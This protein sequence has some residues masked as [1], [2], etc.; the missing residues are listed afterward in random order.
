MDI[1]H[2]RRAET[3]AR[4]SMT[5]WRAAQA[6]HPQ[7]FE[8]RGFPVRIECT[9]DLL[10]LTDTMQEDRFELYQRELGGLSVGD[11]DSLVDALAD[12]AR[13]F[14]ATFHTARAPLPFDTMLATYALYT[15]ICGWPEHGRILEIGPG[16]G[17][18]S[19][20]IKQ[21]RPPLTYAQIEVVES[22]YMLQ[23]LV[24][25]HCFGRRH[26][27]AAALDPAVPDGLIVPAQPAAC[28]HVPWWKIDHTRQQTYDIATCSAAFNEM[29]APAVEQYAALLG[30]TM[31]PGGVLVVQDFG[32]GP[33][34]LE[35]I[36]GRLAEQGFR[37][38]VLTA[39]HHSLAFVVV[40][41]VFVRA[42]HPLYDTLPKDGHPRMSF[43]DHPDVQRMFLAGRE[44]PRRLYTKAEIEALV[45]KALAKPDGSAET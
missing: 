7:L 32:G 2:Y 21:H 39:G 40:N 26:D 33:L 42:G 24:N 37:P 6:H 4:Q 31:G 11:V 30:D 38:L 22:F 36:F 9:A 20:F 5:T 14:T 13:F 3:L 41:G 19:F 43:P 17:Y 35:F 27:E 1:T 34:P 15:K 25:Q 29:S 10:A 18:L 23:N 44:Q 16:C 28:V 12:Y 45:G 8:S